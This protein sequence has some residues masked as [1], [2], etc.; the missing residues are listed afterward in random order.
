MTDAEGEQS[1][2]TAPLSTTSAS[3]DLDSDTLAKIQTSVD[4]PVKANT[5]P[6]VRGLLGPDIIE[7]RLDGN[8]TG[9]TEHRVPQALLPEKTPASNSNANTSAII[10]LFEGID[11]RTRAVATAYLTNP[12]SLLN[13]HQ[14]TGLLSPSEKALLSFRQ[15]TTSP[16]PK[17]SPAHNSD[18]GNNP[19]LFLATWLAL[20]SHD[21]ET[22][23]IEKRIESGRPWQSSGN[24]DPADLRINHLRYKHGSAP[25]R[26]Y[27][28]LGVQG[29]TIHHAARECVSMWFGF[30]SPVSET[31]ERASSEDGTSGGDSINSIPD[32]S[33]VDGDNYEINNSGNNDNKRLIGLIIFDPPREILTTRKT[34]NFWS[35]DDDD[36][37]NEDN[38]T[39][40]KNATQKQQRVEV[41]PD[42]PAY[43]DVFLQN[44]RQSL[45]PS[46][47]S[48]SSYPVHS[49]T[50]NTTT[51]I[52]LRCKNIIRQS[53]FE[54][55]S[56]VLGV[57]TKSLD[58]VELSLSKDAVLVRDTLDVWRGYF[59]RWRNTLCYQAGSLRHLVETAL[60]DSGSPHCDAATVS[61]TTSA[62]K[63]S[64]GE[65]GEDNTIP[66]LQAR[67]LEAVMEEN[68]AMSTRLGSV[69]QAVMST[70]QM[71]E[72]KRAIE[73]AA[74]VS[75]L[76]H[77]AF[78]FI[79]LTL[80]TG[81]FSMNISV[82]FNRIINPSPQIPEYYPSHPLT[83]RTT[84]TQ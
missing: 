76:T 73:E 79:P 84:L 75:K 45:S 62:T 39:D 68:A 1:V 77:L 7:L 64:L 3:A 71:V 65:R 31:G 48:H 54:S 32:Q 69:Y 17:S 83:P 47:S 26:P 53:A 41:F 13:H 6:S 42:M 78:F 2:S 12:D 80:V 40:N 74:L 67:V 70:M 37:D 18:N 24:K 57:L 59:G 11:A 27:H 81:I 14:G 36:D 28:P 16:G 15:A 22:W 55:E 56:S 25:Y 60:S 21:Y 8:K 50:K 58:D 49:S 46:T 33:E 35:G 43:R 30:V 51:N 52:I 44:F 5:T 38:N 23:A 61:S 72:S 4:T 63:P 82:S 66:Q 20:A 9:W 29:E 19:T 10:Y 34:Y